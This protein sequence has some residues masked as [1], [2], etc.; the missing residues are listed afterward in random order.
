MAFLESLPFN[1][2][3]VVVVALILVSGFLAFFRGFITEALAVAG[4]VG[5]AIV[6]IVT[7][8]PAQTLATK[9]FAD[10]L[11]LQLLIDV[12]TGIVLFVVSL[13]VFSMILRAIARLVRGKGA[14]PLDRALG[15]V[16]GLLRGFV[17]LAV[18][19]LLITAIVPEDRLPDDIR[20]ASTLPM[21]RASGAFLLQLAP[22]SLRKLEDGPLKKTRVFDLNGVN[23]HDFSAATSY[24]SAAVRSPCPCGH[25]S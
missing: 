21:I 22:S 12:G 25:Q 15:L 17:L 14:N 16:F 2:V 11:S 19:W 10:I 8:V 6:T 9:Y 24:K 4:W 5:A 20:E 1:V 7:F 13:I 23:P 18:V 3:D